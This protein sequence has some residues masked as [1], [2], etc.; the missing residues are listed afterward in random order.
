ME[1]AA[2]RSVLYVPGN[3]ARKLSRAASVPADAL[4]V[5][6]EDAVA[7]SAKAE[8]RIVTAAAFPSLASGG[9]PV[10]LRVNPC[11]SPWAADD[12]ASAARLAPA[13]VVLPK[14]ETRAQVGEVASQLP[15]R[16]AIIPLLESPLGVLNAAEIASFPNRVQALMFGAEDYSAA[17][18]IK[19]SEGEPEL[20]FA[21]G[22]VVNAA[23]AMGREVFDSPPMQY[24]DLDVV[25][26]AA[27]RGRRLGFT[28]QAAIHPSQVSVI[29]RAFQP[30]AAEIRAAR[31]VVRRFTDHG[32]GVYGVAGTLEDY[33]ALREARAVLARAP[34]DG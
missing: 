22:C 20:A 5:D 14:C 25:R 26:E 8:A 32:G 21:R 15:E 27:E 28:G 3:S 6:W 4:L 7:D 33:P 16:T 1:L 31:N 17:A 9:R 10:L 11:D 30:S 2:I 12:C 29:N 13:G 23:R 34:R 19:R 24:R 18:R